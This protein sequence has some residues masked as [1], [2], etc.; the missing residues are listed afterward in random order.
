MVPLTT[1]DLLHVL[2][3][4]LAFSFALGSKEKRKQIQMNKSKLRLS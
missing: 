4:K 1:H 2:L 3:E